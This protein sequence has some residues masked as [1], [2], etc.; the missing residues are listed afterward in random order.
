MATFYGYNEEGL[1]FLYDCTNEQ[2]DFLVQLITTKGNLSELMTGNKLYQDNKPNHRKYVHLITDE[3]ISFGSNTLSLSKNTYRQILMK[4]CNKRDVN[5]SSSES[6]WDIEDKLLA[7]VFDDA[8][9]QMSESERKALIESLGGNEK[10]LKGKG[11]AGFIALF[12]SGGFTSY[13]LSVIIANALSKAVVGHG[14]KFAT[15]AAL[16]R[17]LAVLTGPLGWVL[18]GLWTAFNLAGPAYRVIVPAVS[19]VAALRRI[20]ENG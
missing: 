18:T 3:I 4:V 20:H 9:D 7:K 5:Y 16:T 17:G 6:T 13:K 14:L 2:L 10:K 8:W 15:N 19:Y 11:A 1:E 12:Q